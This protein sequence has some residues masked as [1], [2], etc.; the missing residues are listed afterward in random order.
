MV[1]EWSASVEPEQNNQYVAVGHIV[2]KKE[3]CIAAMNVLVALQADDEDTLSSLLGIVQKWL[4][5]KALVDLQV[6]DDASVAV[7]ISTYNNNDRSVRIA[8]INALVKLGAG[9]RETL[10]PFLRDIV[11]DPDQDQEICIA[12]MDALETLHAS[13]LDTLV[14]FLRD[15]A[16]VSNQDEE[17]LQAAPDASGQDSLPSIGPSNNKRRASSKD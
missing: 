9:H 10:V 1:Q 14:P 16:Q 8:A 15:I 6:K 2:H 3:S 5:M 7:L 13:D 11:K 4:N 17:V 12:A